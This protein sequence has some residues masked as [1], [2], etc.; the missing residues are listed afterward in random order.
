MEYDLAIIGAG[1][2]GFNAALKA[3]ELGLKAC[4][5]EKSQIGG[6]CLNLGCIPTKTL[7]QS[8]KIF[9]LAK[10]SANFGVEVSSPKLNLL[11]AQERKQNLIRQLASGMQFMLKGVDFIN[12]EAKILSAQEIKAGDKTIKTNFILISSGSQPA[13]LSNL[14]FDGKKV[15]SSDEILN[16][17]EVPRSLLVIGGGVIGCEFASLFSALGSEV[18][19]IEKMPQL[20][21]GLDLE[22]SKKLETIF[23]KKGVK[24]ATNVDAANF[25]PEDYSLALLCVGRAPKTEGLGFDKLGVKT[26]NGRIIVDD[27]LKTSV[28]N[29]YAAGD[30]TGKL[31]LAHFAAYQ[32]RVASEN[33]AL[34]ANPKKADNANVPNCIFTDPEIA[35]VGLSEEEAKARGIEVKINKFDFL[36][37][38]M[39]R[40]LDEAEGFIKII[41]DSKTEKIIGAS[42]I[43]PRATELIASLAIAASCRLT[44]LQI[45]DTIFAHPSLSEAIGE[46]L[47]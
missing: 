14:R 11:R 7:I 43:G 4:I 2:A 27:Y 26:A 21:P 8:A 17:N 33:I 24:V 41:S 16:L 10:K 19:V 13:Q 23:K 12:A 36:A 29:I 46:S 20:L 25:N 28:D 42:I 30:C 32:G 18:T 15:I 1:W 9:S 6:T 34:P 39:A 3:K 44:T 22:T 38:G 35:S 31:M 37:S 47:E 5:I 40:I 45:K